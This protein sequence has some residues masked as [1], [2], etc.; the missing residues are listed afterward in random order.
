MFRVHYGVYKF[1]GSI[2]LQ[3][4]FGEIRPGLH[5]SYR[6]ITKW[7]SEC[8]AKW[9]IHIFFCFCLSMTDCN[10]LCYTGMLLVPP[11]DIRWL[12]PP[13]MRPGYV[14]FVAE[15]GGLRRFQFAH[16]WI[17]LYTS[18]KVTT[19][20]IRRELYT[21]SVPNDELSINTITWTS[22]TDEFIE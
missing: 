13:F 22:L 20:D 3:T 21:L 17:I 8:N 7:E 6:Q 14:C 18:L 5:N 2:C 4:F 12:N 9:W 11:N 19:N 10:L 15:F 16:N 1:Q